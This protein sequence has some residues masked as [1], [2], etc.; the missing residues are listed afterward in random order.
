MGSVESVNQIGL[1]ESPRHS[2]LLQ[3]YSRVEFMTIQSRKSS[4]INFEEASCLNSPSQLPQAK[5][6]C[7]TNDLLL[8]VCL[9]QRQKNANSTRSYSENRKMEQSLLVSNVEALSLSSSNLRQALQPNIQISGDLNP[10]QNNAIRRL[11]K[12]EMK[13]CGD[14]EA[15][16]A[17]RLLLRIFIID[18]RLQALLHLPNV[19]YFELRKNQI[20]ELHV[21][22]VGSTLSFVMLHL[23]NPT[24]M[25]KSLQALGARHVIHTEIQYRSNYWKVVNQAFVEFVNADQ[26][27]IDVFDA[28]N[29]LGNFCVEQMR[30]GYKIEY[31]AQKVLKCLKEKKAK[32]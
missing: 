11:W 20:F 3:R 1:T 23:H 25:S 31:K 6:S 24:A 13:K 18:P 7:V 28:W 26:T 30:I 10:S 27:S 16:L 4:S 15:E 8:P 29:V 14:N 22:A 17:S 2:S 19:P 5:C 9:S 21:K 12:K 32:G